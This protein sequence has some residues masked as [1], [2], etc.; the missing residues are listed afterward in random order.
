AASIG[1]LWRYEPCRRAVLALTSDSSG[2]TVGRRVFFPN[3]LVFLLRM[4]FLFLL[5]SP[6]RI[7]LYMA[8]AKQDAQTKMRVLFVDD[9]LSIRLTLPAILEQQGFEVAV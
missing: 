4:Q 6:A 2:E 1:E 3:A 8:D 5:S 9:E 7:Q